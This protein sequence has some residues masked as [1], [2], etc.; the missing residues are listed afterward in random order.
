MAANKD[1][2]AFLSH[3]GDEVFENALAL[4][5]LALKH[6]PGVLEQI[7]QPARMIAYCY[8]QRYVDMVCTIIPS[9]KGVK[10]GFYKGPELPD[11]S[12][13]LQGSGKLSRY[14]EIKAMTD[15]QGKP[16]TALL[17]AALAAYRERCKI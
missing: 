2:D 13:L 9:K 6:L 10:L 3:Y 16:L 8:G 15:I 1:V 4:R 12:G 14:V 11:P 5:A 17:K 7:D